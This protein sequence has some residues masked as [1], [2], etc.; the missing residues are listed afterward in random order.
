MLLIALPRAV[1]VVISMGNT[2]GGGVDPP[3]TGGHTSIWWQHCSHK[4]NHKLLIK[5]P[6]PIS[7]TVLKDATARGDQAQITGQNRRCGPSVEKDCCRLTSKADST[8]NT[9]NLAKRPLLT[10][11]S[12]RAAAG[13]LSASP[14]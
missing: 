13:V 14:S 4:P 6:C 3:K 12:T 11:T 5:C 2:D 1:A 9:S 8:H 10:T 7:S